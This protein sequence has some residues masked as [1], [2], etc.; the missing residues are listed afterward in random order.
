M[1][2]T[3]QD[4]DIQIARH[5][6]KVLKKHIKNLNSFPN[7]ILVEVSGDKYEDWQFSRLS[8][9]ECAEIDNKCLEEWKKILNKMIYS[10]ECISQQRRNDS[11]KIQEGLNLF[12]KYLNFIW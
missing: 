2:L 1:K 7:S 9:E 6:A 4:P 11:E 3:K 12:A 5:A 10:F 8:K